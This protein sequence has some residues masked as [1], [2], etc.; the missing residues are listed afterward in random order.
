MTMADA[1]A[2]ALVTALHQAAG[3]S[4]KPLVRARAYTLDP[5]AADPQGHELLSWKAQEYAYRQFSQDTDQL[6]TLARG[7][8]TE[9][10]DEDGTTRQRIVARGYDKFFNIGELS[11]TSP[12]SIAAYAE[13]PLAVSHKENGCIIFVA[14]LTPQRLVVTSKHSV[15]ARPDLDD[16]VSHAAM[17]EMWLEKHLAKKQRT[18]EALAAELW[19]R[20]ETAVLELCDDAFEEHVLAYPPERAGLY[21]HG[22][23]ANA[24]EF[25]TRP[26]DEVTAF[27]EAWGLFPVRFQMFSTWADVDAFAKEVARTGTLDNE[28]IEGFVVRARMPDVLPAPQPGIV[29]PPYRPGQTWFFKI[30]F[31]EPYLM[32]R[33]WRELTRTMLREKKTWEDTR[34][35][36]LSLQAASLSVR[37]GDEAA[38]EAQAAAPGA[39]ADASQPTDA[40]QPLDATP[41][42]D[43]P[44]PSKKALKRAKKQAMLAGRAQA[45]ADRAAGLAPPLPP[46]PRSQRPETHLFVQWSYDLLY[47]NPERA[48]EADAALFADLQRNHGI[49]AMRER[50]LAYMATPAGQAALAQ[51]ARTHTTTVRDLRADER[52]Y[53]KTL[54]VPIA[55]PGCGKTALAVALCDLFAWAHT[56]SDD[57]QTKRTGPAFLKNVETELLA[58]DVVVADRNNHLWQHRD[59]LVDLVRRLSD[60]VNGRTGR[61]RLVALAWRIDGLAHSHLQSVCASRIMDRGERHQCLRVETPGVFEF[62][63]ILTRF[64]KDYQAFRSAQAGEGTLGASDD[65]FDDVVWLDVETPLAPTLQSVIAH[66][67]P[68][69]S[70]TMPDDEAIQASV[71]KALAYAPA[72]RKP[73]PKV[74][75]S[76]SVRST[77]VWTTSYVGVFVYADLRDLL[78]QMLD[79]QSPSPEVTSARA[80]LR[81]IADA[82]R[83][84]GR[85]HIT[86]VHRKDVDEGR[87]DAATW[88]RWYSRATGEP[89]ERPSYEL[90][91]TGLHWND[92]VMALEV[93]VSDLLLEPAQKSR[94][95]HITVGTLVSDASAVESNLLFGSADAHHLEWTHP[96]SLSGR[97]AFE[98]NPK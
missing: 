31:D 82:R 69:L 56:Q 83:L 3:R 84:Y 38:A 16:G 29:A 12:L 87:V 67:A 92:R 42:T 60:P 71:D 65:Q 24:A 61:I 54:L 78:E 77:E 21:L 53:S 46:L 68:T 98:S 96:R 20:N 45:H 73:L 90:T 15:G 22:L 7:L 85:P 50:F 34:A 49:I 36:Q 79:M 93:S 39:P 4:D 89:K 28:P 95:P 30:K 10:V 97:L 88:D 76:R 47:G 81:S 27:A 59:E 57:V 25:A 41:P 23:N 32:Y 51:V 52:P 19:R 91:L 86:V 58:H 66:L 48:V 40:S 8:F 44:A 1:S 35:A 33:D 18:T 13:G 37:G 55:V 94:T 63:T 64:I 75:A 72:V 2:D 80:T 14:A 62:D 5:T 74:T 26:M 6:P 9:A 70:L 17:G 11:W 43:T